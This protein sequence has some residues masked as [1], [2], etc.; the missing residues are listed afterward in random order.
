M[1]VLGTWDGRFL[2]AFCMGVLLILITVITM[3]GIGGLVGFGGRRLVSLSP[4]DRLMIRRIPK[5]FTLLCSV[6]D[7]WKYDANFQS[8][9]S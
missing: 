7:F 9:N 4:L 5:S 6:A 3:M 1:G 2:S 8:M